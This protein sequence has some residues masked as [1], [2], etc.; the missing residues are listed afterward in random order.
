[1]PLLLTNWDIFWDFGKVI[2]KNSINFSKGPSTYS[3][4]RLQFWG[5]FSN[6]P[7]KIFL[8]SL[9]LNKG[10]HLWGYLRENS[11][12]F[13][14]QGTKEPP[15]RWWKDGWIQSSA[16]RKSQAGENSRLALDSK[17][18]SVESLISKHYSCTYCSITW[19]CA[20][21]NALILSLNLIS[22]SSIKS[23]H[24]DTNSVSSKE[25]P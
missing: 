9:T 11:Q 4:L 21:F 12:I 5:R 20:S 18:F 6:F 24:S 1:M 16:Y 7:A 10:C 22:V 17:Y 13:F 25:K 8:P 2:W 14:Y 19:S 15:S 3:E 23:I